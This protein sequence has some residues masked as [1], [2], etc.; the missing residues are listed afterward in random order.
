[1]LKQI[2]RL[3]AED[4]LLIVGT[5]GFGIDARYSVYRQAEGDLVPC[6]FAF[7]IENLRSLGIM[8]YFTI[9]EGDDEAALLAELMGAIRAD[10]SYWSK[11]SGRV[12]R[13]L[14]QKGIGRRGPDGFLQP[15]AEEI[16]RSKIRRGIAALWRQIAQE[17]FVTGALKT[18][19]RAGYTAWENAAGDIA[20]RPPADFS[21]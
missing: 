17:H 12:D 15:P 4:G 10:R 3:L 13:L 7:G 14:D 8:P 5:S 16:P 9:R 6:E 19:E 21:P 11:L 1:M 20:I 2:G 18:L